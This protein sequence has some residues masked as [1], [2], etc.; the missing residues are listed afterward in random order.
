MGHGVHLPTTFRLDYQSHIY[1]R[2]V[3]PLDEEHSWVFYYTTTY[4]KTPLRRVRNRVIFHAY[5]NWKQHRNFSGQDKRIVED[6]NYENPRERLSTSDAFPVAWR[7][8]VIQHARRP[9]TRV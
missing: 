1:S 3:T 7:K 6:L 8:M 2:A 4:P 9:V 5:Y